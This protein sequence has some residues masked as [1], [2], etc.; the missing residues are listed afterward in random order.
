MALTE[1]LQKCKSALE[2]NYKAQFKGV[3]LYGSF[4]RDQANPDSDIDV[5]VLPGQPFDYFRE[6]RTIVDLLHPIQLGI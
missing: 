3:I 2:S 4:A 1:L 5:L 6:L